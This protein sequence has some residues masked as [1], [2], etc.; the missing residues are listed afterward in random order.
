M[1]WCSTVRRSR[2]GRKI[3]VPAISTISSAG[4]SSAP[5]LTRDRRRAPAPPRRR[6]RCRRSVMPRRHQAGRQHHMVRARQRPRLSASMPAIGACSGRTLSASAGPGSRR[7]IR[8]RMF[9]EA[10]CAHADSLASSA[11]ERRRAAPARTSAAPSITAATGTSHQAMKAKIAMRRAARRWHLRHVLA[12]ERLQLLD[13]VDHR[14]HDA[15]GALAGEPGR[16]EC[17]DLVVELRLRSA[18]CTRAAVRCAT[19]VR[20]VSSAARSTIAAAAPASGSASSAAGAPRNTRARKRPR[21]AKRAMPMP[22]ASRPSS[23]ASPMRPRSP[24]RH[25]PKSQIEMH[26]APLVLPA[27]V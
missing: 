21:K 27:I 14:Q 25:A 6:R 20:A 11:R 13:A 12:E 15:A 22:S 1:P 23:T 2:N 8:R 16:P 9:C 5:W 26:P 19:M 3:S 18:S 7:E 17:G 24:A 10:R 4:S